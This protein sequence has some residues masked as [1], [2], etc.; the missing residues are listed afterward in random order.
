MKILFLDTFS[1]DPREAIMTNEDFTQII[2]AGQRTGIMGL[3]GALETMAA[4]FKGRPDE[5]IAKELTNRLAKKNYI[6]A[7][8]QGRL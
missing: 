7:K 8:R 3:K 1:R 6:L 4:E 5:E 2:V